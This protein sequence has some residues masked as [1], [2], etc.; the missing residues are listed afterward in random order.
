VDTH[1]REAFEV[2][3]E[4]DDRETAPGG[5]RAEVRIIHEVAG[6]SGR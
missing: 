6:G 4:R 5:E 3:I 1:A 2:S